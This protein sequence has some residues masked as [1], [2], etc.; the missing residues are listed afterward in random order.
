[1]RRVRQIIFG[2]EKRQSHVDDMNSEAVCT[3]GFS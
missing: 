1:M 2:A 3:W